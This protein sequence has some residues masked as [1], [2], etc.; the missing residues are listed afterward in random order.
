V[1]LAIGSQN[2]HNTFQT[3][4]FAPDLT[5]LDSW[6]VYQVDVGFGPG[7]GI[8]LVLAKQEKGGTS[9]RWEMVDGYANGH[10]TFS[11]LSIAS[12]A[13]AQ[14][15]VAMMRTDKNYEIDEAALQMYTAALKTAK[16][17]LEAP[18]SSPK[19]GK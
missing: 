18:K 17:M 9:A 10:L 14:G 8:H 6:Q 13:P 7:S 16:D 15:G 2:P 11:E 4:M 5:K 1:R 3:H 12:P 19:Q